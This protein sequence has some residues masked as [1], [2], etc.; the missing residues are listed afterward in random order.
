LPVELFD[1]SVYYYGCRLNSGCVL[2]S[3]LRLSVDFR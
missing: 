3:S 2:S 1:Y